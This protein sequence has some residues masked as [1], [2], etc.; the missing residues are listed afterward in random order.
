MLPKIEI[1]LTIDNGMQFKAQNILEYYLAKGVI[2]DSRYQVNPQIV[3]IT[4]GFGD[5]WVNNNL[6]INKIESRIK[7]KK[8]V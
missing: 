3:D 4:V 1:Q 8:G 7:E 2:Q 6:Y 5:K